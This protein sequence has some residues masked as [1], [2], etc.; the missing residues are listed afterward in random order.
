M[1]DVRLMVIFSSS[2]AREPPGSQIAINQAINLLVAININKITNDKIQCE[3][4]SWRQGWRHPTSDLRRERA[5]ASLALAS[6]SCDYQRASSSLLLVVGS[7]VFLLLAC[8]QQEEASKSSQQALQAS[9]WQP[10][11]V[12]LFLACEI[13]LLSKVTTQRR[14]K[15]ER[16]V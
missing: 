9:C 16:C 15:G 14:K 10:I 7:R 2:K 11:A 5:K 6:S 3:H 12:E 1:R 4:Y 8:C 13:K